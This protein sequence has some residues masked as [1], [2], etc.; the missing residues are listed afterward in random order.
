[1]HAPFEWTATDHHHP[2]CSPVVQCL[3][4]CWLGPVWEAAQERLRAHVK[5][6]RR[7]SVEYLPW[8]SPKWLP[9]VTEELGEVAR[10]ICELNLSS[11]LRTERRDNMREEL[12]QVMAMCLAWVVAIDCG[13]REEPPRFIPGQEE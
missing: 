1:M 12:V 8:D 13:R 10:E 4:E 5:H 9:I 2:D 11:A 3:G 7:G 6:G